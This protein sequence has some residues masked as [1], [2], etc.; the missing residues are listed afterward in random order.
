M[1]QAWRNEI[2]NAYGD[3]PVFIFSSHGGS[4]DGEWVCK[5]G[6]DATQLHVPTVAWVLH[7]LFGDDY[8]IMLLVCNPAGHHLFVP[9]V[10][11]SHRVMWLIPGKPEV[12]LTKDGPEAA[13]WNA[14]QLHIGATTQ[15][16]N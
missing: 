12:R 14:L 8:R 10:L 6:D 15:P 4:R 5:R 2:Q 1:I 3:K 9:G 7:D 16:S 11:H 13:D